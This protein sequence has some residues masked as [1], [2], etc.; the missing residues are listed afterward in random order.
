V[1]SSQIGVVREKIAREVGKHVFSLDES[2]AEGV[3]GG[4]FGICWSSWECAAVQVLAQFNFRT[5]SNI[6]LISWHI[7]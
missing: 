5:K 4:P 7:E 3:D 2:P 6:T 1:N